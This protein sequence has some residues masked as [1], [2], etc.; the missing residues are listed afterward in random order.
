MSKKILLVIVVLCAA[1]TVNAQRRTVTVNNNCPKVYIGLSTGINNQTGLLGVNFDFPA[2]EY[3]S[4]GTGVGLSSWGY[5]TYLEG[6]FYFKSDCNRG[7][8]IGTGATYN[9]GLEDFTTPMSTTVGEQDVT[10]DL[11]PTANVFVAGYRFFN[12]GKRG[13]RFY[14]QLGYSVN[15]SNNDYTILSNHTLDDVGRTTMR[16]LTPGGIILGLGFSFGIGGG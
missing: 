2:T 6:R 8:A 5:K 11:N 12:L 9:T 3:L 14:L 7:W 15:L 16:L 10:L 13:H 1:I 4:I